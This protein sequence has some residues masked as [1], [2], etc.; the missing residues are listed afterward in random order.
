MIPGLADF[1]VQGIRESRNYR[2]QERR[3]QRKR[4][5]R[6]KEYAN[7][8]KARIHHGPAEYDAHGKI[9]CILF[10]IRTSTRQVERKRGTARKSA[11]KPGKPNALARPDQF[12]QHVTDKTNARDEH[13]EKPNCMRVQ[14]LKAW[15]S[16]RLVRQ[17]R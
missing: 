15:W 9:G 12:N 14:H 3:Q 10:V 6:H 16:E 1:Q 2:N 4:K 17:E 13:H 5:R 11:Q 7:Q 8:V